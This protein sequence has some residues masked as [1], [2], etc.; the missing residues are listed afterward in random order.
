MG[1]QSLPAG[2]ALQ[3][4]KRPA[5]DLTPRFVLLMLVESGRNL[6]SSRRTL[7]R[8]MHRDWGRALHIEIPDSL[9][10][11]ESRQRLRENC[12]PEMRAQVDRVLASED[13]F[14][15]SSRANSLWNLIWR[16]VMPAAIPVTVILW[17]LTK[18][19]LDTTG[20]G[21]AKQLILVAALFAVYWYLLILCLV[22]QHSLLPWYGRLIQLLFRRTTTN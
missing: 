21:I 7:L 3:Q 19:P 1:E 2:E 15:T 5:Q 20:P 6:F 11:D 17:T 10:L 8:R 22:T 14:I 16:G 9:E 13:W 18:S 4:E 12:K